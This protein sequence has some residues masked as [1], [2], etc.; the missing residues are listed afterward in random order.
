MMVT[1]HAEIPEILRD[2]QADE[3]AAYHN[4]AAGFV[5]IDVI[6]DPEGVLHRTQGKHPAA[7][8]ARQIR[9]DGFAPGESRSLS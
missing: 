9:P 1:S 5:F 7:V 8:D 2:L 3:A 6:L 4:G